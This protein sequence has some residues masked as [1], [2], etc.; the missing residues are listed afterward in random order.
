MKKILI[1]YP[2]FERGGVEKILENL[3]IFFSKKKKLVYLITNK[4]SI[5]IIKKKNI[6]II[7]IRKINKFPF[8][9]KSA[10][11]IGPAFV[12]T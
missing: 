8:K 9:K 3:C 12:G 6:K 7:P 10:N 2:S 11:V 1:F 4:K 5:K